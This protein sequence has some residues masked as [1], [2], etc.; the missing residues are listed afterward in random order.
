MTDGESKTFLKWK[1]KRPAQCAIKCD[2][3]SVTL[4]EK[5]SIYVVRSHLI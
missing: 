3:N 4:V 5:R 1:I 2:L